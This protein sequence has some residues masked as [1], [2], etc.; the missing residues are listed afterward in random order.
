MWSNASTLLVNHLQ[1]QGQILEFFYEFIAKD[2]F[3]MNLFLILFIFFIFPS[4]VFSEEVRICSSIAFTEKPPF[5]LSKDE[6]RLV[7]GDS[8][9]GDASSVAWA[10][11]SPAQAKLELKAMFQT[12]GYHKAQFTLRQTDLLVDLG[13]STIISNIHLTGAPGELDIN[14]KREIR[15][16]KLTPKKLDEL[17]EWVSYELKHRGYPCPQVDV[18][19]DLNSGEI[20]VTID[21]GYKLNISQI[22]EDP[23]GDLHPKVLRRYDAF[24]LDDL[25][26]IWNVTLTER[27]AMEDDLVLGTHFSEKCFPSGV[28]LHQSVQPGLP[29]LFRIGVGFDTE[30]GPLFKVS[31]HY[32][33][34][35]QRGSSLESSLSTSFLIQDFKAAFNWYVLK[36]PSRFFLK[37]NV[38]VKRDK[39]SK[40]TTFQTIAGIL[41]AVNWD[42]TYNRWS[43]TLGPSYETDQTL[44]GVGPAYSQNLFL[45][46]SLLLTSHDY[47]YF[48]ESPQRGYKIE[49]DSGFSNQS[50]ISNV[51]ATQLSAN[52]E[53][54]FNIGKFSPPVLILGL[55]G[56]YGTTLTPNQ[57]SDLTALPISF[58]YFLGGTQNLRGFS[59]TELSSNGGLGSMTEAYLGFESRFTAVLPWGLQPFLFTDAGAL[60]MSPNTLD[61]PLYWS[62]G[63]G[64]RWASPIGAIR[65]EAAHGFLDSPVVALDSDRSHWQFYLSYGEEF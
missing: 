60:G 18:A 34:L 28:T 24:H 12:R 50:I 3:L 29:R 51:T 14:R 57:S 52:A 38:E 15:G 25:F 65:V 13:K 44:S 45:K 39:E 58:R 10:N 47:E 55:R 49:V 5:K 9:A 64:I 4:T 6:I 17:Q 61:W 7:C 59:R 43:A 53:T 42:D 23:V 32:S 41:P 56:G 33:R 40:F 26:D 27:R 22:T 8:G 48:E 62:P 1:P 2:F 46:E 54:L 35:N 16:E 36:D 31:S 30:Q 19:A 11:I 63:V 20:L 21:R 37:P